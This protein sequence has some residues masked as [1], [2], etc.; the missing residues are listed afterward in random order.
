M[1]RRRLRIKKVKK[2]STPRFTMYSLNEKIY[3]MD[4]TFHKSDD[5]P[6]P[7]V[8]HGH[9]SD[10]HYRLSIWDGKVY[11]KQSGKLEYVGR[12]KR[13][14]LQA[15]YKIAA[16]QTFIVK[17]REWYKENHPMCPPLSPFSGQRVTMRRY[18]MRNNRTMEV[19]E[20]IS[21]TLSIVIA[22]NDI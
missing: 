6:N 4:W 11:K 12:A 3:K 18:S 1:K 13:K 16:F 20:T 17:S 15:L 8:P 21:V 19:P 7:S 14:E 22:K 10:N 9:S 5:D 2:V